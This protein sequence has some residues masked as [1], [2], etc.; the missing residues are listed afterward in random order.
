MPAAMASTTLSATHWKVAE[1]RR[2]GGRKVAVSRASSRKPKGILFT[3]VGVGY[4][5][6][7]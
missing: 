4:L 6:G 1:A 3:T 2:S 5:A 7:G